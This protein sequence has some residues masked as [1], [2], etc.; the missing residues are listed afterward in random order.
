[1]KI[2]YCTH[3]ICNPGGMERVLFNKVSWISSHTPWEVMIVTTDQHGRPP[4]YPFPEQVATV[5]LGID[6]SDD[7]GR[8]SLSRILAFTKKKSLHRRRLS[9]L[10]CREKPDVTVSMYPSESSFLPS[11]KDG[12]RKVLELHYNRYFRLQYGRKG[13]A[14]LS[15]RFRTWLD[16]RIAGRFDRFVVL[17]KEDLGYWGDMP[18]MLAIPNAAVLPY[19]IEADMSAA[20]VIAVGRLDYQKGFDRLI[21]VWNAVSRSGVATGW[22]LDIFGQGE[23]KEKLQD[24]I[25][26]FGLADTVSI[27]PPVKDIAKEYARS[28]VLVMTSHYEGLPM[29][30]LEA[31][32]AGIPVVSFDCKC[33]PKDLI[34]DGENG[35]LIKDGDTGAMAAALERMIS[36]GALRQRMSACARKVSEE[37]SQERIM[38]RWMHLFM[39]I[40]SE[41]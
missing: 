39:S 37:Y 9:E 17:T 32:S 38:E 31:L 4:F 8:N 21:K 18:N 35:F 33:G 7:I 16:R 41:R 14:G 26:G 19:K 12:S 23:C 1:M 29:V 40:V 27:N 2:I 36:D 34:R 6:Y 3:S 28:S 30:M 13:L 10:L 11:L 22:R 24:M 20:R 5:D 15:D 25:E